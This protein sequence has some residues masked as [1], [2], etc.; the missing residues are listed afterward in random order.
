M[1]QNTCQILLLLMFT[2]WFA[3]SGMGDGIPA[4][5]Y[6]V[7][8][9]DS[10]EVVVLRS[11]VVVCV[12]DVVALYDDSRWMHVRGHV[13]ETLKGQ[14]ASPTIEFDL[15][16]DTNYPSEV[17][18]AGNQKP[19]WVFC[20][21]E[22]SR[23]VMAPPNMR[24]VGDDVGARIPVAPSKQ[25]TLVTPDPRLGLPYFY[26]DSP[27]EISG[28]VIDQQF[29]AHLR[30]V[31]GEHPA[32]L[33]GANVGWTFRSND[34]VKYREHVLLT[35]E[36]IAKA[37]KLVLSDD[38]LSRRQAIGILGGDPSRKSVSL[39]RTLLNDPYC[40]HD[41]NSNKFLYCHFPVRAEA[42]RALVGLGVN[43][44]RP[45]VDAPADARVPFS[46]RATGTIVAAIIL[47]TLGAGALWLGGPSRGLSRGVGALTAL[48]FVCAMGLIA[49]WISSRW[50]IQQLEFD[51]SGGRRIELCA[52][53]I[54]LQCTWITGWPLSGPPAFTSLP[55]GRELDGAWD[56]SISTN[57]LRSDIKD[58]GCCRVGR[59]FDA[60]G[61]ERLGFFGSYQW[62]VFVLPYWLPII[63]CL[64]GPA[65]ALTLGTVRRRRAARNHC[66]G[67]GYDLRAT[68]ERCPECGRAVTP[69]VDSRRTLEIR[70]I[71]ERSAQRKAA[72]DALSELDLGANDQE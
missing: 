27:T 25:A 49:L 9:P 28:G 48:S 58:Y 71:N 68:T 60:S 8:I 47:A 7:G 40:E 50:R 42:Y 10:P 14:V 19:L 37:E 21:V 53:P 61:S 12:S 24:A 4:P 29:L 20:L 52:A 35:P 34:R 70:R 33:A 2:S 11:D 56:V 26:F 13:V 55:V 57:Y 69:P 36:L 45:I 22:P 32:G 59:G 62:R 51:R 16:P 39:L 3:P 17:L 44:S 6:R 30:R 23:F 64:G 72:A 38:V 18:Q 41:V 54:G 66:T 65:M 5:W 1:G 15:L 46:P 63:G 67:C 31:I 43:V